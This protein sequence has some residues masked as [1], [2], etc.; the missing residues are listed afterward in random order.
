MTEERG[1]AEETGGV[2]RRKGCCGDFGET[3]SRPHYRTTSTTLWVKSGMTTTTWDN[4][5]RNKNVEEERNYDRRGVRDVEDW[6]RVDRGLDVKNGFL[7]RI[8]SLGD[9]GY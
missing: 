9:V 3:A 7:M 8:R 4:L 6:N 5:G 1:V 2:D